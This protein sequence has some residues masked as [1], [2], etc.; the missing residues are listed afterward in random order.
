MTME[1]KA[2]KLIELTDIPRVFRM[3]LENILFGIAAG[4]PPES[5]DDLQKLRSVLVNGLN[6]II[7][8]FVPI[9]ARMIPEEVMDKSIEYWGSPEGRLLAK[10]TPSIQEECQAVAEKWAENNV[11]KRIDALEAGQPFSESN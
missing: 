2:R 9:Y 3:A 11:V 5:K 6:D 10:L 4:S 7:E 8:E 1:E